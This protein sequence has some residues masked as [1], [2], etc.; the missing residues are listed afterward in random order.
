MP[1]LRAPRRFAR[2]RRRLTPALNP[3]ANRR[4]RSSMLR[5]ASNTPKWRGHTF[6]GD[7][8]SPRSAPLRYLFQ[9]AR[10]DASRA[11]SRRAFV[12]WFPMAYPTGAIDVP[13]AR[14]F[15]AR[16]CRVATIRHRNSTVHP[17]AL[18][19]CQPVIAGALCRNLGL[20]VSKRD[21][22]QKGREGHLSMFGGIT[23]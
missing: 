13:R 9:K 12:T 17:R 19:I 1:R 14:V 3:L 22:P 20:G 16:K 11:F 6:G 15:W 4:N 18:S 10:D 5:Y 2:R 8:Q 21:R 7:P 23:L